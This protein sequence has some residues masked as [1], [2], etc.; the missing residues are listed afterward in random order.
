MMD[1]V[2]ATEMGVGELLRGQASAQPDRPFLY[3]AGSPGTAKNDAATFGAVAAA[4]E[5]TADALRALGIRPGELVAQMMP[6]SVAYV[7]T[8]FGLALCG[9]PVVLVNTAF[10][11]YMLEYVLND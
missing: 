3:Y 8:Y 5:R 11:G 7:E 2:S 10:R 4:A 9:A 1:E 6:N